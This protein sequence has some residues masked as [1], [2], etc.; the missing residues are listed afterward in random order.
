MKNDLIKILAIETSCDETSAAV[1]GVENSSPVILSNVVSSQIDL[2]AKTGGVVPE[3]ASR[4]HVEAMIP[5]IE[6]AI[7]KS[8]IKDQKSKKS[9][10][11]LF[12]GITH[13]AVTAGPGLIGSLLVGFN[14]AKALAYALDIPIV[15][16]N[17]IEGHIYSALAQN[18]ITKIQDTLLRQSYGG[19]AKYKQIS[20]K[21]QIQNSKSI[22]CNPSP[23]TFPVLALTVSGGHTSLTLM[24][25]HGKYQSVGATIDDAAGEAFDKVAKLLDLGYPGGPAVSKNAELYRNRI[26]NSRQLKTN[27]TS[28]A[29]FLIFKEKKKNQ[30]ESVKKVSA[31]PTCGSRAIPNIKF[32]RP[33]LNSPNFDF[34]FS[35]LKTA[36]LYAIQK[37]T[38]DNYQLTIY[39][40]QKICYE[41]EEAVI[42]VLSE[43][44][45]RAVK[46]LKPKAVILAGGVSANKRLR[47]FLGN[48]L[49]EEAN[50]LLMPPLDLCGDNAAMIGLAAYYH[51][52]RGNISSWD[53]IKVDSNLKL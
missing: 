2:H 32:P 44:T 52:I 33:L 1:I 45:L 46:E 10:D 31:L 17:H 51:V 28:N 27:N 49:K 36:V 6:E 20:N 25:N 34:S 41:F 50:K 40:K 24:L 7:E 22:T 37:L 30:Y 12:K 43:K 53:K 15:P 48:K 23:I 4:A 8:K 5:V 11:S 47:D 9:K 26:I 29:Q 38:A 18:R 35:G 21:L 13:I 3:V 39:D 14:T 16:I 42:D 19:Q